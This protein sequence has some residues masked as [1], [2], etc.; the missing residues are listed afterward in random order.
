MKE[1]E[2]NEKEEKEKKEE[3]D[4]EA[5]KRMRRRRMEDGGEDD[6]RS[7][8]RSI[9]QGALT[10]SDSRVER[11]RA[12]AKGKRPMQRDKGKKGE[13]NDNGAAAAAAAGQYHQKQLERERGHLKEPFNLTAYVRS[14]DK[15]V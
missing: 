15:H 13:M 8:S 6:R 11:Q 3:D 4:K 1:E 14:E 12:Y 9:K 10:E 5:E 7:S 2:K